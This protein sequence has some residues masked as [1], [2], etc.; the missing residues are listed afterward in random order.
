MLYIAVIIL[1]FQTPEIA[2]GHEYF[3]QRVEYKIEVTLD[4]S[5]HHLYGT[6]I[7][8]YHNNSPDTL[9]E[10]YYHLYLNAFRPG[11]SMQIRGDIIRNRIYRRI[12]SLKPD[13]YGWTKV[14]Y[15]KADG[16]KIEFE[17]ND[18]ILKA[19][20][21]KPL[22]PGSSV[23]LEMKFES[24]IPKQTRR[25]GRNN[26]EGI[27]YSMAQWYPKICEYDLEG[28]HPDPYIER[29]FYGVW[30]NFD[31]SITLP[32][33]YLVGATGVIQNPKEV[34]CGYELGA[35]DTVIFPSQWQK[36]T[37]KLKTWRF[38][39]ENVHDFAWVADRDYIHEITWVEI[40]GDTVI[41]HLLYQPDVYNL[42]LEAGEFTRKILELYSR[43]YGKYPYKSFTVAQAGDGGMEYPMLIMIT[44]RRSRTSMIGILAHEIGHNWFYGLLGNNESKEAWLDEGFATFVTSKVMRE[45][46]GERWKT[47][48]GISGFLRPESDI[49]GGYRNYIKYTQ[50]GYE[51][52]VLLHSDFFRESITYVNAVYGKGAAFLEMLEYVVGDSVFDLIMK[53][54]FKEWHFKHPTT[55]DF[56]RIAEKIS[57]MELD[58]LF[59]QW[60]KT[61]RTCDYSIEEVY[62]RWEREG[63]KKRY[64]LKVKLKNRDQIVMPIELM[65]KF[66][67][68]DERRVI[69]P[70]DI[71]LKSKNKPGAIVLPPW[72]WVDPEYEFKLE[73]EKEVK[74]VEIDPE[75]KLR[76]M[77]RLNNRSG[78]LNKIDFKF[79]K[80]MQFNPPIDKYW[81][82]F[83]PS[84]WFADV[85]GVRAGMFLNGA[86]LYDNYRT[87]LGIWFNSRTKNFDYLFRYENNTSRFLG[88]LTEFKLEVSKIHGLRKIYFEISKD[89]RPVYLTVPPFAK[90]SIFAEH[91]SIV[92]DKLP[93]YTMFWDKGNYN[94]AGLNLSWMNSDGRLYQWINFGLKTSFAT[95]RKIFTNL[96]LELSQR[97][98]SRYFQLSGKLYTAISFGFD[99]ASEVPIQE[100]FYLTANPV[101][102]FNNVSYRMISMIDERF[103]EKLNLF[104]KGGFNLR[105]YYNHPDIF[106]VKGVAVNLELNFINPVRLLSLINPS[107]FADFAMVDARRVE[108]ESHMDSETVIPV[109]RGSNLYA[110]AGFEMSLKPLKFI[111]SIAGNLINNFN[112]LKITAVFPIWVNKPPVGEERFK[113]RWAIEI[114]VDM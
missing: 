79:L 46:L 88:R 29:E 68:G 105:G 94:S 30:G 31:V 3:Q 70:L 64:V 53:T 107:I 27:D 90:I 113:F 16:E 109:E 40:D 81:I 75:F 100:R 32:S 55:K 93:F 67:D 43:W 102:Q 77:N 61:T 12:V 83:R 11:S 63:G 112:N 66:K 8:I 9:R 41:V 6:E 71:Q 26:R 101:E 84:I 5:N 20:L 45:F 18:T 69:I 59:D 80:Q 110:D 111:P 86:Y 15:I 57:G 50:L 95:S 24:Q 36:E 106:V 49:Y 91:I 92:E 104:L 48:G 22:P 13:E 42:W 58:W 54:Y 62:G 10:I 87:E 28:W 108:R 19:K 56:E 38:K 37:G 82:T 85:D 7:A 96:K 89:I 98:V 1:L 33:D 2:P 21:K 51:E 39:A 114:K 47:S 103:S 52:P 76:D 72:K 99:K 23:K 44:G 14:E 60:L 78:F 35:V 34:L 25:N 97:S 65:L 74:Y 73:L 17:I 4:P